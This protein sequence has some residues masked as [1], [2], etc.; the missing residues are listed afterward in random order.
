ML[1]AK[2]PHLYCLPCAAHCID[3]MLEN[4]GKK[5]RKDSFNS[6]CNK[7]LHLHQWL[8]LWPYIYG[9]YDEKVHRTR[10]SA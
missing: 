8:H 2:R 5:Y 7:K 6:G 9:E 3:L 10:K 4:I 1:M